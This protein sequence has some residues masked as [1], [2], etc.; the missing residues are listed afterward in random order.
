MLPQHQ[1]CPIWHNPCHV[2]ELPQKSSLQ[3][4]QTQYLLGWNQMSWRL[5][6]FL[7]AEQK[8]LKMKNRYGFRFQNQ[9]LLLFLIRGVRQRS[10]VASLCLRKSHIISFIF[11]EPRN[12]FKPESSFH[13]NMRK[14]TPPLHDHIRTQSTLKK[15]AIFM[16]TPSSNLLVLF[17]D[18]SFPSS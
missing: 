6:S 1:I 2:C 15:L 11:L 17:F 8:E 9:F 18:A 13:C 5:I 4:P 3:L 14:P 12:N 10:R 7:S 16:L